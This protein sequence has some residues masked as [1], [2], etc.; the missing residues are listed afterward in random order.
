MKRRANKTHTPSGGRLYLNLE[1]H[2]HDKNYWTTNPDLILWLLTI[3]HLT[4][5]EMAVF[6]SIVVAYE[7]DPEH[8]PVRISASQLAAKLGF[9]RTAIQKAFWRL[10]GRNIL[11]KVSGAGKAANI[12]APNVDSLQRVV[13][14]LANG[15]NPKEIDLAP[16]EDKT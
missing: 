7:R 15:T 3:E 14:E 5:L 4:G 9:R 1:E 8:T 13:L 12:Y 11:V 2:G 16:N 10:V 6:V